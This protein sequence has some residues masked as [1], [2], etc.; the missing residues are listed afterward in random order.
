MISQ[1]DQGLRDFFLFIST[2][3]WKI[4]NLIHLENAL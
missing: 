4:K 1:A 2:L 3:M